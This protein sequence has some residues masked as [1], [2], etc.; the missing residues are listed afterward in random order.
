ME[1][2]VPTT[3]EVKN[4]DLILIESDRSHLSAPHFSAKN[5][6]SEEIMAEKWGAEK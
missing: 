1:I 4:S 3:Q 2:D 6:A 5:L